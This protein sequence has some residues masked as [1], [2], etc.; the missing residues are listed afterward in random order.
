MIGGCL[1]EKEGSSRGMYIRSPPDIP[2][3]GEIAI[4]LCEYLNMRRDNGDWRIW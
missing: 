2:K 1:E 3:S 4:C